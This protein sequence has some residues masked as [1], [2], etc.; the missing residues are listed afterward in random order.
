[1][2]PKICKKQIVPKFVI[3]SLNI[4]NPSV[5]CIWWFIATEILMN[6]DVSNYS[7]PIK[8]YYDTLLGDKAHL[9]GES[10]HL[11]CTHGG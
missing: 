2:N 10:I 4:I 11:R 9:A 8:S 5:K 3:N 1:M 7:C 6:P